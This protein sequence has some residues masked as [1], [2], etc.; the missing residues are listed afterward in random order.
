MSERFKIYKE[1]LT[2]LKKFLNQQKQGHIVTLAMMI[3]GIVMG[4]KAQLSAIGSELPLKQKDSSIVE[5]MRRFV[6]NDT[7]EVATYYMPFA[8]LLLESLP[9]APLVLAMDGSQVGRGCMTLMLGVIYKKRTLPLCWIVYKGKK[10]HT[11]AERHIELLELARPLIPEDAEVILLGDGEYDNVEMLEWIEEK[12]NWKFVVRTAKNI[13]ICTDDKKMPLEQLDVSKGGQ[14]SVSEI[15]FT[16]E[17]YGSLLAIAWWGEEYE[18][19][20]YL[21]SNLPEAVQA[22]MY[23]KKR[24]RIETLFSDQKSRGFHIHKSHLSEPKR[25]SRLLLATCLTYT[26]MIYL[27]QEVIAQNKRA[28]IDRTSRRDKSLFRL[29][30]D[31]FKYLFKHGRRIRVCFNIALT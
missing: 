7:I 15:G 26:W 23:Y 2:T 13:T 29:G 8:S 12:T 14:K 28:L 22:C 4:K 21:I 20:I 5:R 11:T 18:E 30:M 3:S 27:G 17:G 9:K 31:W 16:S 24:Y 19:P 1:V 6:K 25:I 10:G